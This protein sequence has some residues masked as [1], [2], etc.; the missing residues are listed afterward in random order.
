MI[1]FGLD[2]DG[3]LANFNEAFAQMF[4]ERGYPMPDYHHAFPPIWDYPTRFGVPSD[5]QREVWQTIATN[6]TFWRD[7]EVLPECKRDDLFH[8]LRELESQEHWEF[9]FLTHRMGVKAMQQSAQWID[10]EI[11][12]KHPQVLVVPGSKAALSRE[13]H[14]DVV[15]DD[16]PE[17][18]RQYTTVEHPATVYHILRPYNQMFQYPDAIRVPSVHATI[19]HFLSPDAAKEA[20]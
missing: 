7:L 6:P 4:R 3:C 18:L 5:V 10:R 1:R 8:T 19:Q 14:L 17:A 20:A 11:G 2:L 9:Y 13:M 15:Y 16:M 12:L